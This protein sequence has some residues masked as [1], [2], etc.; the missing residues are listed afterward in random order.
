MFGHRP[1]EELL[2]GEWALDGL[3]FTGKIEHKPDIT[4]IIGR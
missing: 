4:D 3:V 2:K 1:F